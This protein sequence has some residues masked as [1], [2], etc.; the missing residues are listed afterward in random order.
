MRSLHPLAIIGEIMIMGIL[1][2]MLF[3]LH[4][5]LPRSTHTIRGLYRALSITAVCMIITLPL[6]YRSIQN[7]ILQEEIA[8]IAAILLTGETSILENG[9]M[10]MDIVINA[11]RLL[12]A[13]YIAFY[14]FIPV[15]TWGF[16]YAM[17]ILAPRFFYHRVENLYRLESFTISKNLVWTLIISGILLALVYAT[18]QSQSLIFYGLTN[19]IALLAVLYILQGIACALRLLMHAYESKKAMRLFAI[20]ASIALC[21]PIFNIIMIVALFS[22]GLGYTWINY[23]DFFGRSIDHDDDNR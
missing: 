10:L 2:C 1:M 6:V 19:S 8:A 5:P 12:S 15:A 20:G 22:F 11:M 21:I 4:T 7:P 17:C 13:T 9:D 23:D 16:M 3:V 14:F 18:R